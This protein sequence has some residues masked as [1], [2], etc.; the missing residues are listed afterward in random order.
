MNSHLNKS[1]FN[2]LYSE[3]VEK[4]FKIVS[5]NQPI[6]EPIDDRTKKTKD[7]RG[8]CGK[9]YLVG[10]GPGD[11]DLLTLKAY[12]LLQTADVVLFDSLISKDI[13]AMIGPQANQIHVGKRANCHI[14]TQSEINRQL[15]THARMGA[16]VVRLKGGDPFIFG[17]GGEEL[18]VLVKNHIRY[19]VV[20]GITAASGCASYAGIPLTHRDF[21]Q[22]V[23]LVTAHQ[24]QRDTIDWQSLAS[25]NQ[26]L[27]FYMG[28]LR[29]KLI[30]D[31]LIKHGLNP[32]M[33][34]AVI[35]NGTRK[36]Q[37]VFVGKID[38]LE[39]LVEKNNVQMPA[40]ILVG[41]VVALSEQLAWFESESETQHPLV[42]ATFEL[43]EKSVT[44]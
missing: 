30:S 10:A 7:V 38:Q 14:A 17:R 13:L 18:Q 12:R 43:G 23:R 8:K 16:M 40:L 2:R 26:T 25:E 6:I 9:V 31:S 27:V 34:V 5:E 1:S 33:P 28:L 36:N 42:E 29:N 11:P 35:E 3:N 22:S 21:S 41:E 32:K 20:P 4:M 44:A 37:R 19:E 15:V 39:E 24:K